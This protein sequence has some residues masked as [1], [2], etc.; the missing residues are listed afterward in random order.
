VWVFQSCVVG[1]ATKDMVMGGYSARCKGGRGP[2]GRGCGLT[3][4]T[5]IRQGASRSVETSGKESGGSGGGTIIGKGMARPE[6]GRAL[7]T[8]EESSPGRCE[9]YGDGEESSKRAPS[10]FFCTGGRMAQR[11]RTCRGD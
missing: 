5:N 6:E 2:L 7:L 8:H 3:L 4:G 10:F 1:G 11:M 9:N